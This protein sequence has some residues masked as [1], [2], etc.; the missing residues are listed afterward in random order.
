MRNTNSIRGVFAA[1]ALALLLTAFNSISTNAQSTLFNIPSTDVVS[2]KKV[3]LEMDFV[4]H[5]ESHAD[6]GFQTYVPR[7]VIG[8][9]K[10]VEVGV[11]VSATDAFAPDQPVYISPNIKWQFHN[12]ESNGTAA[13]VGALLYTPIANRSGVDTFGFL[14]FVA[15]KKFK[16]ANGARLTGGGYALPGLRDGNGTKGGAIV[17]YEQPISSKVTFLTDWFSGKNAFG[18]VTPGFSFAT[19]KK[20]IL[21]IGYSVGNHGRKNNALFIYYGITL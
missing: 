11:N 13:S 18:Y 10:G 12:N 8:V 1:M 15:S 5:L 16:G 14:Y 2:E 7:A 3:Y 6:G 9:A 20:S 4:S 17:G 19:T 21:N